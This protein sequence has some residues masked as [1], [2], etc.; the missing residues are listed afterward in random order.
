[1]LLELVPA[2]EP[3]GFSR[4]TCTCRALLHQISEHAPAVLEQMAAAVKPGGWL[5]RT[6]LV[7]EKRESERKRAVA[8]KRAARYRRR[9]SR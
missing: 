1:V 8:A 7:R 3:H 6:A 2:A 5:D 4:W 9:G